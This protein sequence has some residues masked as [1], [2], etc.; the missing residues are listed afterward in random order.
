MSKNIEKYSTNIRASTILP[1]MNNDNYLFY[2]GMSF[3][4]IR[5]IPSMFGHKFGEFLDTKKICVYKRKKHKKK[6]NR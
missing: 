2:N 3:R 5:V 6:R 4:K 1:L